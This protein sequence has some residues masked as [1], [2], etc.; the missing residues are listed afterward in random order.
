VLHTVISIPHSQN[1]S[2]YPFDMLGACQLSQPEPNIP[3]KIGTKFGLTDGYA[4][5]LGNYVDVTSWY[6]E[7]D[8]T[9]TYDIII[10]KNWH[11]KTRNHVFQITFYTCWM[12]IGRCERIDDQ[13]LYLNWHWKSFDRTKA[14]TGKFTTIARQ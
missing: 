14:A 11:S 10:G 4:A 2:V 6:T 13:H 7:F 8:L 3:P 12:P 9:G 1:S 5:S